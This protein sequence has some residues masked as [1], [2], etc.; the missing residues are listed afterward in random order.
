MKRIEYLA[1]IDYMSG[2]LSGRQDLNY[3]TQETRAYDIPVGQ[4]AAANNYS[5]RLIG[6]YIAKSN[7][8]FFMVRTRSTVNATTTYRHNLAIS[9]GTFAIFYAIR[10]NNSIYNVCVQAWEADSA[11]KTLRKYI[12]DII[13]AAVV[14]KN[15]TI[16]IGS[17]RVDNPWI[18]LSTPN[19]QI[20]QTII[21]KFAEYL[22]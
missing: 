10:N 7:R 2:N 18:V 16:E 14:A 17:A 3:T 9:G 4:S 11:G 20:S 21:D 22:S 1:P 15:A 5:P 13:R 12:C 6:R 19:I 8:R